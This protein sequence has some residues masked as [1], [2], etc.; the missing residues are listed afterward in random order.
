MKAYGLV[1]LP[2]LFAVMDKLEILGEYIQ[3]VWL[4]FQG[5]ISTVSLNGGITKQFPID[6]GVCQGC[7]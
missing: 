1:S 2:F 6:R 4:H 5:A 3:M 7:P